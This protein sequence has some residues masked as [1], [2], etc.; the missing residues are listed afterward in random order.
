MSRIQDTLPAGTTFCWKL[1]PWIKMEVEM[2][3]D[4]DLEEQQRMLEKSLPTFSFC[5]D[6]YNN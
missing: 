5:S 1:D 3:E 4:W 6:Y 2:K